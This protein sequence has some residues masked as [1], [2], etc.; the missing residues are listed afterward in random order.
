MGFSKSQFQNDRSFFI[1]LYQIFEKY[2]CNLYV[3][4]DETF[5][6]CIDKNILKKKYL[7]DYVKIKPLPQTSNFNEKLKKI[8]R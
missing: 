4:K 3:A 7:K 6:D 8:L 1:N 2:N 5:L